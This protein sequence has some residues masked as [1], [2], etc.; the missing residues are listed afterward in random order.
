MSEKSSQ[1][2]NYT[3]RPPLFMEADKSLSTDD[4]AQAEGACYKIGKIGKPHGVKGEVTL[5]FDDDVFDRVDAEYLALELDGIL[6]PFFMEEYRF[7]SNES[8][9]VKFCDVD[10]QE[11]ARQLTGCHVYFPRYLS[12]DAVEDLSW[13][14]IVN[15]QL[16]DFHSKQQVGD[17]VSVD[18]STL[19]I[20]FEVRTN[21][22]KNLLIPASEQLIKSVDTEKR[23]IIVELPQ[24]ILDLD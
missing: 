12:D 16:I 19:N 18:D 9:L 15:F 24:G 6:V 4:N 13:A 14:A 1:Q 5:M 23:Q 17:I 11:Q 21:E 10:T 7:R 3:L 8:A 22:G 2:P 20:L